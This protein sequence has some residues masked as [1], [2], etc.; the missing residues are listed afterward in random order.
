MLRRCGNISEAAAGE[1][2][3]KAGATGTTICGLPMTILER[4]WQ[5]RLV[6]ENC[7]ERDNFRRA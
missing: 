4:Y 7:E 5:T 6:V 1:G 2:A 3:R